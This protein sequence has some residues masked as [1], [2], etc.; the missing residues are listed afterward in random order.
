MPSY[1]CIGKLARIVDDVA[2]DTSKV[3][4]SLGVI[5]VSELGGSLVQ[6]RVGRYAVS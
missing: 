2:D 4:M 3:A 1:F 6:A 5:E